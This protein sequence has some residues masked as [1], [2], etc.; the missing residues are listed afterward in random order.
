MPSGSNAQKNR[1]GS[2]AAGA[3]EIST[4]PDCVETP[5]VEFRPVDDGEIERY[6]ATGSPLD[7]AGGYGIQDLDERWIASTEGPRDNVVGLPVG[8]VREWLA[9]LA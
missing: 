2:G 9:A 8:R 6:V 4:G 5:A 1:A 3:T 7:K